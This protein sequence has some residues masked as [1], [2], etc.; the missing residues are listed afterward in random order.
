M[1]QP[2]SV[3][4]LPARARSE[5]PPI[6][7]PQPIAST[8]ERPP[9]LHLGTRGK[10]I[11]RLL[12]LGIAGA[13][14]VV[15][16]AGE[17]KVALDVEGKVRTVHTYARNA[18]ELL[19][20]KGIDP[21]RSDLVTPAT[22]TIDGGERVIY[23]R[24]KTIRLVVDGEPRRVVARGLTVG[25]ALTDLGLVPGPKDHVF[26]ARSEKLRPSMELFVRNAVH[27][28]LRVD[29]RL[30][31]V[32]TSADTVRNLLVQAGVSVGEQDYVFP[33]PDTEPSDGM[34][35]RVV[36]VRRIEQA[37]NVRI[38]FRYVSQRDAN[39][40]SGVRKLIQQG[41]E[42]LKVQRFRIVLE[43]GR[44]VS[45]T[46]LGERVVRTSRDHIVRVGT[47]EPTFKGGGGSQE[48]FASWYSS[49]GLVAAH[50][51][52]PMGSVVRVVAAD[53]G[54]AVNVRITD[55][56]PWVDGRVIDLSDDAFQR[57][58]PLGKGTVKVK[59]QS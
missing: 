2:A 36:R 24:A 20:R 12:L 52:L 23:R 19:E 16:F 49:D 37:R 39:M 55:R 14:P 8:P 59:V 21:G 26:P 48:G 40:E 43:D 28:K 47:K 50:R 4:A 11:L 51:S 53:T 18:P 54:K 13:A 5:S 25:D 7:P 17:R 3:T 15:A 33:A 46:L 9:G 44:R 10:W 1:A 6:R 32:V 31:D 27:T 56:G 45:S 42:G 57:L 35:I 30:R 22:A 58:A 41:S 29:G 38:P 34:W